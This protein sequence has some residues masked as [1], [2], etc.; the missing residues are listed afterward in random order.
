MPLAEERPCLGCVPPDL[1]LMENF[2]SADAAATRIT[3]LSAK[4]MQHFSCSR[5]AGTH[6]VCYRGIPSRWGL[7]PRY[8]GQFIDGP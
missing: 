7:L 4:G 3:A 5:R 8:E 6:Y 2:A 1:R